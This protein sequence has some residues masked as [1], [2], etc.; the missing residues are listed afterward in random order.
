M[1]VWMCNTS[2]F[3]VGRKHL[4]KSSRA[5]ANWLSSPLSLR[6]IFTYILTYTHMDAC[7]AVQ[8]SGQEVRLNA[9]FWICTRYSTS[10]HGGN[11]NNYNNNQQSSAIT[12]GVAGRYKMPKAAGSHWNRGVPLCIRPIHFYSYTHSRTFGVHV[13]VGEVLWEN[14]WNTLTHADTALANMLSCIWIFRVNL[15]NNSFHLWWC[16][17]AF[18]LL[19]LVLISIS[20]N[21]NW[22][23]FFLLCL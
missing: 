3:G 22:F 10:A 11:N 19:L 7:T 18:K 13:R 12:S 14:V 15:C 6:F 2:V 9:L 17:R 21:P 1:H 16:C 4:V 20:K 5:A 8:S 23:F